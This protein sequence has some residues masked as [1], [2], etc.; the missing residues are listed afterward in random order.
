MDGKRTAMGK[1]KF[2]IRATPPPR[3]V[4]DAVDKNG[5]CE[6]SVL[7]N[8]IVRASL[9]DFDFDGLKYA[10]TSFRIIGTNKGSPVSA[11]QK[12]GMGFTKEMQ[13]IIANAPTGSTIVIKNI[14]A[15]LIGSKKP[16]GPVDD[17]ISI[18]I[19]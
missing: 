12:S 1:V 3:G 19:K 13:T 10:V 4:V 6:R 18:E 14:R 17:S 5:M 2:R 15:K 9:K 16:P 8:A 7:K 11:E